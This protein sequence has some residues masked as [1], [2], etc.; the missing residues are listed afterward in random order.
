[1]MDIIA[2]HNNTKYFF[3]KL[4]VVM[5]IIINNIYNMYNSF[6]K[7]RTAM[8]DNIATP[9]KQTTLVGTIKRNNTNHSFGKHAK[10]I[11]YEYIYW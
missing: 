5:V 7:P 6:V 3:R 4:Q 11:P 2:N 9:T 8:V 1:M 10:N